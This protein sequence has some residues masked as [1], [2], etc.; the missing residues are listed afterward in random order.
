MPEHLKSVY[1]ARINI[2]GV[3]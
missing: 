2:H 1:K 3:S